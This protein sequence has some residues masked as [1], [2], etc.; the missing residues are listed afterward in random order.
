MDFSLDGRPSSA[1]SCTD[2]HQSPSL[3]RDGPDG[4][5][6]ELKPGEIQEPKTLPGGNW[7]ESR[8]M[9]GGEDSAWASPE[10][11]SLRNLKHVKP[12]SAVVPDEYD[13]RG[14]CTIR[15]HRLGLGQ[16]QLVEFCTWT[17][18]HDHPRAT[19]PPP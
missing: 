10:K 16:P 7:R 4:S 13:C 12:W 3:A 8:E 2:A 11:A 17:Q 19:E 5:P 9:D 6:R 15:Y 1:L 14:L 18:V